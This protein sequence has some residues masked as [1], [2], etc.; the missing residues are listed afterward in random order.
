MEH[1][2]KPRSYV[3]QS[4]NQENNRVYHRNRKHLHTSTAEASNGYKQYTS[5]NNSV[6]ED[7]S[8]NPPSETQTNN[9]ESDTNEDRSSVS[10]DQENNDSVVITRS[11]RRVKKPK[12]YE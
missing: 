8:D 2:G 1:Y 12:K 6:N 7:H 3:V 4:D 9:T 5:S 10:V 11:G